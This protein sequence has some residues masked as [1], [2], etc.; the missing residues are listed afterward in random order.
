MFKRNE[1]FHDEY[2]EFLNNVID[3][4]Y[5]EAVPQGQLRCKDRKLWYIPHH[6]VYHPKKGNSP[7]S[8]RNQGLFH[9]VKVSEED[10]NF[11]I[12]L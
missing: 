8:A 11:L 2:N 6:G 3:K 5:A 12:F 10:V 4:G 7:D 1:A 9:Q